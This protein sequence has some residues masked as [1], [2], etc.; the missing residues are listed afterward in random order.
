LQDQGRGL[1]VDAGSVGVTLSGAGR[2]AGPP[3][4]GRPDAALGSLAGQAFIAETE[5]QACGFAHCFRPLPGPSCLQ[6]FASIHVE[7]Q[8]YDQ[9]VGSLFH[10]QSREDAGIIRD[11]L[12]TGQRREGRGRPHFQIAEGDADATLAKIDTD[13]ASRLAP[14]RLSGHG[15]ALVDGLGVGLAEGVPESTVEGD[16]DTPAGGDPVTP[17]VG[18]PATDPEGDARAVGGAA[19]VAGGTTGPLVD[20]EPR[21]GEA[22]GLG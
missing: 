16:S 1:S 11:I 7:R 22:P 14:D 18:E 9:N 17:G 12:A 6:T 8:S 4:A 3:S 10:G 20:P 21:L 19:R 15:Y 13:N 2:A 5:R